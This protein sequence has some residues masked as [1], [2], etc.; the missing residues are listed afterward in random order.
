[1]DREQEIKELDKLLEKVS[2]GAGF[3]HLD[4]TVSANRKYV[5][6][7]ILDAGYRKELPPKEEQK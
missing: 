3:N 1:M 7:T 2:L 6:V 5:V 4:I